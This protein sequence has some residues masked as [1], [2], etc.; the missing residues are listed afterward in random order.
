MCKVIKFDYI[1]RLKKLQNFENEIQQF[2]PQNVIWQFF[3]SLSVFFTYMFTFEERITS[4]TH[5]FR[6][7]LRM[8]EWKQVIM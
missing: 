6:S 7:S 5:F 4:M 2:D 8:K 3:S 1:L